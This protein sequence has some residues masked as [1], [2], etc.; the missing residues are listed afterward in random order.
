MSKRIPN[1]YFEDILTAIKDI[2]EFTKGMTFESFEE[3]KKTVQAV[4]RS[5]E[6]IGE[7]ANAIP[8]ELKSKYTNLPWRDMISLRNKVLHEYFGV[9]TEILWQ[10]ITEDLLPLKQKVEKL[11]EELKN[12]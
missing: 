10:T 4:T 2:K 9:D 11:L 6:I 1:L 8:Q 3:D 5:L 7:A 12:L